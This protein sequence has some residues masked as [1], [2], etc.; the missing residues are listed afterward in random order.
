MAIGDFQIISFLFSL[1]SVPTFLELVLN[2][3]L[4][5]ETTCYYQGYIKNHPHSAV[6]INICSG[7]RGTI[8]TGEVMY[9][10]EPDGPLLDFRHIMYNIQ[11]SGDDIKCDQNVSS[12]ETEGANTDNA[13]ETSERRTAYLELFMVVSYLQFKFHDENATSLTES[14]LELINHVNTVFQALNTQIVLVGLEI[15]SN[16]NLINTERGSGNEILSDFLEWK[17]AS[18]DNR[19]TYDAVGLSLR[20]NQMSSSGLARWRGACDPDNSA[21]ISVMNQDKLL[22]SAAT[23]IHDLGHVLGMKHDT[24]GCSC[25]SGKLACAMAEEGMLSSTFSD[26][27]VI[28][29]EKF[30]AS[31]KS[32][33]LWN[34]PH[35]DVR[36]QCGNNMV[37]TGEKCSSGSV[38]ICQNNVC[39]N[40][41]TC[42]LKE[43]ATCSS[44]PC[45]HKCKLAPKGTVCRSPRTECD[46]AEYCDGKS[47]TCPAD[48]YTQDGSPCN[49]GQSVCYKKNCYDYNEHCERLFGKGASVAPF[50]CFQAVNTAGDRFGNC[51]INGE[52]LRCNIE[53]VMCGQIQCYNV[54]NNLNHHKLASYVTT[55][56]G[57]LLCWGLEFHHKGFYD[58]S[59]VP[60]GALCDKGKI[61]MDRKC[62]DLSI[63]EYDCDKQKCDGKGVCNNMKNCHCDVNWA[64]PYCNQSGYGGSVDSGPVTK[65]SF[66]RYIAPKQARSA[67]KMGCRVYFNEKKMNF[68]EFTKWL[69]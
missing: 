10:I 34:A 32:S 26:C 62:V 5:D 21:F 54:S 61:C 14:M 6:A 51:G 64:P 60:N 58:K 19:I 2:I 1:H 24:L 35:S 49:D 44:G 17:N 43:N 9:I 40:P 47:S 33:C 63:L 18:L 11:P 65:N 15:W 68:L 50:P 67:V 7:L 69:Q 39:C 31:D 37:E 29:M 20:E 12:L 25:Q 28:D 56:V 3:L 16:G 59:A 4:T 36:V 38:E 41:V 27:S 52:V 55:P 30:Y 45:C 23:F 53:D 57:D 46:L 42:E 66:I 22:V 48:V 13:M 8:Y